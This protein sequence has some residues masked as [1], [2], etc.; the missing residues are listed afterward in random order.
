MGRSLFVVDGRLDIWMMMVARHGNRFHI[1]NPFSLI[2]LF[3]APPENA[4][5]LYFFTL[6][7]SSVKEFCDRLMERVN[8][9]TKCMQNQC[10]AP[11]T[12]KSHLSQQCG[13]IESGFLRGVS[14]FL[15]IPHT[16]AP[17]QQ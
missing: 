17:E 6:C 13:V 7:G 8:F 5:V 16:P 10:C 14:A 4:L 1:G 9:A 2:V 15:I 12:I 11:P 3:I